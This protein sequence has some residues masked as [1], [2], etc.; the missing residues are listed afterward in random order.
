VVSAKAII[1]QT[2]TRLAS[3]EMVLVNGA[4]KGYGFAVH[5]LLPTYV[6]MYTTHEEAVHAMNG[7]NAIGFQVSLAKESFSTRLKQLQ[8]DASTNIYISNIPVTLTD[9]DVRFPFGVLISVVFA[10][11]FEGAGG[12]D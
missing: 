9:D 3:G 1:D 11:V 10:V 2:P 12:G 7:L 8:D 5:P 6:Q 4:C